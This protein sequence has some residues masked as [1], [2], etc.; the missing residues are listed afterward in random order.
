M[1]IQESDIHFRFSGGAANSNPLLSIGGAKSSVSYG[2][3]ANA[4]WDN[5]STGERTSG[6]VEYRCWYVHN[7]SSLKAIGMVIWIAQG[8]L[9]T[10]DEIDI[11]LEGAVNATAQGPLANESTA[12]TGVTFSHPTSFG[13]GLIIGDLPA[14]E[15]RIVWERRTVQAGAPA[16]TDNMAIIMVKGETP[17]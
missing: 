8:T 15:H 2:E 12:P 11:G 3:T 4:I 13:G 17:D 1:V 14:G 7:N 10:G 5:I 9:A 16:K 6:D